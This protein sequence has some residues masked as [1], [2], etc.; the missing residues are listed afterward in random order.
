MLN[1]SSLDV[2]ELTYY[3]SKKFCINADETE[4]LFGALNVLDIAVVVPTYCFY[5]GNIKGSSYQLL[6]LNINSHGFLS[7]VKSR[8]DNRRPVNTELSMKSR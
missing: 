6:I 7:N 8:S 1:I 4:A 5:R 3:D 2:V